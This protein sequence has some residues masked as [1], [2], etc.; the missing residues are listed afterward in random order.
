MHLSKQQTTTVA[1]ASYEVLSAYSSALGE[2]AKP[3]WEDCS[4]KKRADMIV[5]VAAVLRAQVTPEQLH[6]RWLARKLRDGW[7]L[8]PRR[9]EA[10]KQHPCIRVYARLPPEQRAKGII[11]RAMC[12]EVARIF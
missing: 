12:F 9:D 7:T 8:G 10:T 6:E 11:C 4:P 3:V 5:T 1:R 2:P